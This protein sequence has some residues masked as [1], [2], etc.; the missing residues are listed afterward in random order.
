MVLEIYD[1]MFTRLRRGS[2]GVVNSW[3]LFK[4]LIHGVDFYWKKFFVLSLLIIVLVGGVYFARNFQKSSA[5]FAF[6][7]DAIYQS[8]GP[9]NVYVD[10]SPNGKVIVD[11]KTDKNALRIYQDYD[12]VRII[13]V[14]NPGYFL[15]N[16]KVVVSLPKPVDTKQVKQITYAIHGTGGHKNTM[17][18][19]QTLVYQVD[20]IASTATVTVVAYLPKGTVN[21]SLGKLIP[22]YLGSISAQS[23]LTTALILPILTLFIVLFMLIKRRK[24]QIIALNVSPINKPLGPIAPAVIG[25]LI[26]G[27]VSAREIT[28]TLVDLAVRGY[29]YIIR[30]NNNTFSFGKR[31]GVNFENSPDI[32]PYEK[33]LLSKI[34]EPASYKSSREDV[35]MRVGHHIFSRKIAQVFLGIYNEVT[36]AGYFISNP[37]SVHRRWKYTGIVLYILGLLGFIQSAL[38]APDP[39]LTLIFWVGE[40][41]ASMVIIR[42]SGLMPTRSA[43]GSEALRWWVAFRKYLKLNQPIEPG[44]EHKNM[45][46]KYLP[47][48]I[49]F[50]VEV[51]WAKRF[52]REEFCTPDWFESGDISMSL[53]KFVAELF[54]LVSFVG[55]ILAKSHDPTVE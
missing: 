4:E 52:L 32:K 36:T 28:A 34:F 53:E 41:L 40:L 17:Q 10:V 27:Q 8:F 44:I 51:Q 49:I 20:E 37:A 30:K 15:E 7:N 13:I 31:K 1:L 23:Y 26:D 6:S 33:I 50:G 25:V 2:G 29:I 18:D 11:G 47:Y 54:P 24:D 35:E 38:Y 39:K 5:E 21:P 12:E 19:S 14:D 16:L 3:H 46:V 42:I 55:G 48:A 43:R 9:K 45:F 22:Y